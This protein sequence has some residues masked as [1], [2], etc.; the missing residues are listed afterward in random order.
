MSRLVQFREF[1]SCNATS[2]PAGYDG[3]HPNTLGE[4]QIAHAFSQTLQTSFDVGNSALVIPASIPTRAIPAPPNVQST[5]T[6]QNITIT[7]DKVY[8]VSG[9]AVRSRVKGEEDWGEDDSEQ[10]KWIKNLTKKGRKWEVQVAS[11]YGNEVGDYG[12]M[13]EVVEK[14]ATSM[15][16]SS[17]GLDWAVVAAAVLSVVLTSSFVAV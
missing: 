6:G 10:T 5:S 14:K 13:A 4:Y 8:G 7:W 1:Y 12:A 9:Y 17:V 2:C 15:A 16:A 3:L 11:T